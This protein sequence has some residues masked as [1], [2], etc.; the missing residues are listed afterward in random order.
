MEVLDIAAL[1][2]WHADFEMCQLS[3][4]TGEEAELGHE[5]KR[6]GNDKATFYPL[7]CHP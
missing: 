1:H 6:K 7:K 3:Q 4:S 2:C 5:G